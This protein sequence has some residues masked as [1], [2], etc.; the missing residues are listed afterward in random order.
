LN[1]KVKDLDKSIDPWS[2]YVLELDT[3][4]DVETSEG[5]EAIDALED[6]EFIDLDFTNGALG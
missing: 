3:L 4:V 1:E 5:M 6:I 2:L